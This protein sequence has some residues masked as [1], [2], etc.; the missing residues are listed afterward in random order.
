MYLY[1]YMYVHT[2]LSLS[3]SYIFK[4]SRQGSRQCMGPMHGFMGLRLNPCIASAARREPM[5]P[6]VHIQV[7][8]R[9]VNPC[10]TMQPSGR[11]E[12]EIERGG[13]WGGGGNQIERERERETLRE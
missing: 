2:Y 5:H 6:P 13:G 10:I 3:L 12:R 8:I 9:G 11:G 1:A 4:G 7:D